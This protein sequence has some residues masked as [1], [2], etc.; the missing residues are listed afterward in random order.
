MGAPG[1]V[2]CKDCGSEDSCW[3]GSGSDTG[4]QDCFIDS[5][6]NCEVNT[7]TWGDC[8]AYPAP[9]EDDPIEEEPI[10]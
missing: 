10:P 6:G 7:D 5:E 2:Y 3:V 1:S 4:Y 9:I 8:N